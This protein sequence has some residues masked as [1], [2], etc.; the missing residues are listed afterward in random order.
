[1]SDLPSQD[2]IDHFDAFSLWITPPGT[3]NIEF[4]SNNIPSRE[5][6]VEAGWVEV[7]IGCAPEKLV[8]A[9]Y[10]IQTKRLQYSLKHIGAITINKA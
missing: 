8:P 5:E 7:R 3:H 4:H 10:G 6:L 1:M 9:R 2:T